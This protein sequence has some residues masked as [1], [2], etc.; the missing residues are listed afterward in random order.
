MYVVSD[1]RQ[2]GLIRSTP[3]DIIAKN[4]DRRF[5]REQKKELAI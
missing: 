5:L 3:Q 1:M 2:V 4:T